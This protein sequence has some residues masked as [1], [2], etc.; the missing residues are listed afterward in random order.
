MTVPH[1]L[2]IQKLKICDAEQT[3]SIQCLWGIP[4]PWDCLAWLPNPSIEHPKGWGGH[5]FSGHP[6]PVPY[7]PHREE[8][9]PI[10]N[11]TLL[12][13]SLKP[14]P[15]AQSLHALFKSSCSALLYP[16]WKVLY[17]LCMLSSPCHNPALRRLQPVRFPPSLAF[18]ISLLT[19]GKV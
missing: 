15:L 7:H 14:S 6:V 3:W 4:L 12:F 2:S 19:P 13:F 18:L 9:L 1:S 10:A 17:F 8:I 5:S 11:L 16:Y